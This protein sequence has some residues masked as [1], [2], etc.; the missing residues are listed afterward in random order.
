MQAVGFHILIGEDGET[1]GGT[2]SLL[3]VHLMIAGDE[4]HDEL[5]LV[6]LAGERLHGGGF[7]DAQE[8]GELGDGVHAGRGTFSISGTS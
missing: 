8:L 6:V 7:R 5:A 3:L 2:G 1:A 4:Q